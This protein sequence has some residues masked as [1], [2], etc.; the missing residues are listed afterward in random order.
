MLVNAASL[1]LS[2]GRKGVCEFRNKELSLTISRI[3]CESFKLDDK[4]VRQSLSLST[5]LSEA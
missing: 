5:G 3:P 4:I 2:G 1:I